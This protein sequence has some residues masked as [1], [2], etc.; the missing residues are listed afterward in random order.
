MRGGAV[1]GGVEDG[2]VVGGELG[3]GLAAGA[4][5]HGGGVVEVGDGDG[6]DADVG[7]E[8]RDGAGDGGLLGAAGEAVGAVFY[9]AAGD[10]L[11]CLEQQRGAYAEVAV[12][13]V[14]VLGGEGGLGDEFGLL[15]G[16]DGGSVHRA[17]V[18][19][20]RRR[21]SGGVGDG[22]AEEGF[23][24]FKGFGFGDEEEAVAGLEDGVWPGEEDGV[25]AEDGEEAGV[26]DG[27]AGWALLDLLAGPRALRLEDAG[28][29][30]GPVGEVELDAFLQERGEVEVGD[31]GGPGDAAVV[32]E[33][34]GDLYLLGLVGGRV[35]AVGDLG[36]VEAAVLDEAGEVELHQVA[37]QHGE[38]GGD[39]EL[40]AAG[41]LR[42][43]EH[44]GDGH[45]GRAAKDRRHA[46]D[47]HAR[48]R[49]MRDGGE[50]AAQHR[51][52]VEAGSEDAAGAAGGDGEGER[53][54]LGDKQD[55]EEVKCE[56]AVDG[57]LDPAVAAGED[58]RELERDE[59]DEEAADAGLEPRRNRDG[60]E[61]VAEAV[62][63]LRQ[64][65]GDDA[66]GDAE[67]RVPAV[68]DEARG[69]ELGGHLEE[70]LKADEGT[71]DGVGDDGGEEA[72]EEAFGFELHAGV[73]DLDGEDGG[74]DGG[75]EDGGEAGGHAGEDEETAFAVGAVQ[76]AGVDGG[77]AGGDERGGA[78]T[79]GRAAGADGDG[80][81]DHLERS[82]AR[83]E[84]AV[85]PMQRFDHGVGTVAFCLG[86]PS[87]DDGAGDEAADGG[88]DGDEPQAVR[89]DVLGEAAAFAGKAGRGVAG[90]CDEEELLREVEQ[91][92]E[93]LRREA[94]D[95]AE[96]E[97]VEEET[98]FVGDGDGCGR[99]HRSVGFDA[100]K[101]RM[102][103]RT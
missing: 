52:D 85:G 28:D 72:V 64:H 21:G 66:A 65:R 29:E 82:D 10:G 54:H 11:T 30:L 43:H 77:E 101:H 33:A 94:A 3:E 45:T 15:G 40:V 17:S 27:R 22:G 7:A 46:D 36:L 88:D 91:P 67:Q 39:E 25:A 20:G 87:V 6:S 103:S 73:E 18:P 35:G 75:A 96:D 44:G 24:G 84:G 80:R 48:G 37:E 19:H 93:E 38:A 81:G 23:E 2:G 9:V 102:E 31:L 60:V 50:D 56:L 86:R 99:L 47:D 62:E 5:G 4:A 95:D 53:D 51:T 42:H 97:G 55:E 59:A 78:F 34:D 32:E 58:L 98:G 12:G 1:V 68:V 16:G 71:V 13:R 26:V 83:A 79:A 69:R 74:A 90:E 57:L 61:G 92:G 14:G 89:A 100:V 76:V 41:H 63:E 49:M 70:R 8:L